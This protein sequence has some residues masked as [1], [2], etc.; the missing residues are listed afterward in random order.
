LDDLYNIIN[1]TS[2]EE[3][4][5]TVAKI[6]GAPPPPLT[7]FSSNPQPVGDNGEIFEVS[8]TMF[9]KK[10]DILI[11]QLFAASC[12]NEIYSA[13][14]IINLKG[15]D[16]FDCSYTKSR[17][18]NVDFGLLDFIYK[19][20]VDKASNANFFENATNQ[21][22]EKI[23]P[24]VQKY[25]DYVKITLGRDTRY[26]S[27][28]RERETNIKK[29]LD[30]MNNIN[31]II[32]SK[33][34]GEDNFKQVMNSIDSL[35]RLFSDEFISK[36]QLTGVSSIQIKVEKLL[37]MTNEI[38][39]LQ[40]TKTFFEKSKGIN[41]YYDK[42]QTKS[43]MDLINE[44][45]KEKYFY[46]TNTVKFIKE[47]FINSNRES[48][49]TQINKMMNTYFNN[50]SNDFI[51]KVVIPAKNAINENEDI[52]CADYFNTLVTKT[53]PSNDQ[54]DPE[55]EINL[56]V[57]VIVGKIDYQNQQNITCN[58]R[59]QNLIQMYNELTSSP[60]EFEVLKK[61]NTI[62]LSNIID[63]VKKDVTNIATENKIPAL[64]PAIPVTGGIRKRRTYRGRGKKIHKYTRKIH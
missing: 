9:L 37:K 34:N 21:I 41:L 13:P 62:F 30:E 35:K 26:G 40:L 44:L 3:Y 23:K 36:Y 33:L 10:I 11:Y 39:A 64:P 17:I 42:E 15:I 29:I 47:K 58:Y 53:R 52:G 61:N 51:T 4:S 43:N 16:K 5:N 63:N 32:K 59:D 8:S 12:G 7:R 45:K 20:D 2:V 46:F 22:K 18:K 31:N 49:N 24:F 25:N 48:T 56:Y 60:N 14:K 57:E 6:G 55:Y 1:D 50:T 19:D 54:K 38:K 28:I 27:Y